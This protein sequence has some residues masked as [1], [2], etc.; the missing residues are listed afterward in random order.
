MRI[1]E[2][3]PWRKNRMHELTLIPIPDIGEIEPNTNLVKTLC[4]S[5]RAT[6]LPVRTRDIL[7]LAQK[8]VS[9]SQGRFVDLASVAVSPEAREIAAITGKDPRLV[10]LV[11]GESSEVLRAKKDVLIVRHKLGFVMANA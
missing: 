7:V 3:R 8:I 11:L 6:Q 9:K 1:G 2:H 5:L 4:E 10:Q